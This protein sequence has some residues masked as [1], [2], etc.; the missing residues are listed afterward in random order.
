M[1][2]LYNFVILSICYTV[3]ILRE[4]WECLPSS[5]PYFCIPVFTKQSRRR[6]NKGR[7]GGEMREFSIS[8]DYWNESY[9][10]EGNFHFFTSV[11][12]H[13]SFNG[14]LVRLL[15]ASQEPL[16]KNISLNNMALMR[17]DHYSHSWNYQIIITVPSVQSL[18]WFIQHS[19]QQCHSK[20]ISHLIATEKGLMN[21]HVW[22]NLFN[23]IC[24]LLLHCSTIVHLFKVLCLLHK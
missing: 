2:S 24:S 8:H 10:S 9:I 1:F 6:G 16:L 13:G 14:V 5:L 18:P 7:R 11:M 15:A 12:L 22:N 23:Y 3:R 4:P 19:L 21:M 17:R 20:D